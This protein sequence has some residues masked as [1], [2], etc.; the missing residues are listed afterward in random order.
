MGEKPRPR[1]RRPAALKPQGLPTTEAGEK[2]ADQLQRKLI[3]MIDAAALT[4][5]NRRRATAIDAT[6][7]EAG[8]DRIAGP[9]KQET[10]IAIVADVA[11]YTD[12]API[13]QI[14]EI[15]GG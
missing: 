4:E 9:K 13:V 12:I 6:D 15:V 10:V 8:F 1:N 14:S 7:C 3:E 11:N 2:V 5:A